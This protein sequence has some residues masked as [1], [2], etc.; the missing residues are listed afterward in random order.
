MKR[1]TI[2]LLGIMLYCSS[3]QA[4]SWGDMLK[5]LLGS[6]TTTSQPTQNIVYPTAKQIVGKWVYQ[7]LDM[8]YTGDNAIASM[9]VSTAKT[10]LSAIA[11]MA[12]LTSGKDYVK[13]SNN[14]TFNLQ[15]GE[16]KIEGTYSYNPSNGKL[17]IT[18]GEML[19]TEATVT[20]VD[21]YGRIM[22]NAKEAALTVEQHSDTFKENTTFRLMK[23]IFVAYPEITVGALMKR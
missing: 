20:L 5:G 13:L 2:I 16:R 9:G 1:L 23:E 7:Q 4:Q 8:D 10:Q 21:G 19:R 6:E 17:I 15:S 12:K 14:G 18:V 22:F 11:S 3:A